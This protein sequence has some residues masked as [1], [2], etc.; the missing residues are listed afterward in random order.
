MGRLVGIWGRPF[1]DMGGVIDSSALPAIDDELTRGLARIEP[2]QTGGSLKHMGVTAPWVNDD[3]YTDYGQVIERFTFEEW[4][5][6]VELADEPSSFDRDRWRDV[7]FGDETDH[8]LNAR[9]IRYLTYRHGVYFPWKVCVHLLENDRWDDKHSGAG[10]DFTDAAKALFPTTVAWLKDL[11]FTEMGR[12]VV[13]GLLAN[14]HA[15]AHRALEP[16]RQRSGQ[17]LAAKER[18]ERARVPR[19]LGGGLGQVDGHL[20]GAR[21][22]WRPRSPPRCSDVTMYMKIP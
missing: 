12:V 5:A 7:R 9:Q 21:E 17:A 19:A 20:V 16:G 4:R 22:S 10:K 2:G 8:P 14:D 13:F 11:P 3:G 18:R 6:L 1:I 15:P